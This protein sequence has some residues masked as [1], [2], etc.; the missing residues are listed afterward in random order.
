MT[1]PALQERFQAL[2]DGHKKILYKVLQ[3]VLQEP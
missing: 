3:F 1:A 2:V